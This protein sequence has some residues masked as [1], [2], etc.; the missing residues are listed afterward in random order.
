MIHVLTSALRMLTRAKSFSTA[1]ILTLALG[2]AGTTV[3]VTLV[4][5]VVL[6]PLPV[7]DQDRL[8]VAWKDLPATG[9][10]HHPFGAAEIEAVARESRLIEAA[11]GVDGN[12]AR[13]AVITEDGASAYVNAAVVTGAF[14][15]VLGVRAL[16][17]RA[18]APADD[19]EGA[20]KVVVISHALWT[21]RYANGA[22]VIGWRI[23]LDRTRFT[24]VGVMPADVEHPGR[25]E[26][27]RTTK[28]F[29]TSGPFGDAARRE[30]DLLARLRPGVTLEQVAGE[31]TTLTRAFEAQASSPYT[32]GL[33]PVVRPFEET[34]VGN[35]RP[36]LLGLLAAVVL[37]LL[38]AIAN[39]ANL[40]LMRGESRQT[41]L[42]VREALGAG[43]ARIVRDLLAESLVFSTAAALLGAL[44]ARWSL[45][46]LIALAPE[47]LPR[48]EAIRIDGLVILG[49]VLVGIGASALAA[50][51]PA[52]SVRRA[53]LVSHLRS[54]SRGATR[55][56]ARRARRVLV[57]AQLALAVL[58]VAAAGVLI[59][60][61][62][63]LQTLP[64]G[65]AASDLVF[66]ELSLPSGIYGNR[67]R[68]TR[69]LEDA[70]AALQSAP[71]IAAATPINVMPFSG[72]AGWDVPRFTAEGQSADAAASNP[73]LPDWKRDAWFDGTLPA[74]DRALDPEQPSAPSIPRY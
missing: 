41:E 19:V 15:D 67:A 35:V 60:T 45:P 74:G 57:V 42:A 54:E 65:F 6:R 1:A 21:R 69:L 13:R 48:L 20:G 34:V 7:R 39:V 38:I 49:I 14:F 44:L 62:W 64:S 3:M 36:V 63:R 40:Q 58:V 24:I 23:D 4:R 28:S 17:G 8:I 59:R 30:I 52:W 11:A 37:V 26:I 68:H 50:I 43:R 18:L 5:G 47:G 29:S 71:G 73:S 56:A 10:S 32:R 53:D 16:V 22:D 25:T 72:D 9:F 70:T 2:I 55:P 33:I 46:V 51:A 66:V 31:L 27:W 12:G 61:L